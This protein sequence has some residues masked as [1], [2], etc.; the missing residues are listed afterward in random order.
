NVPKNTAS[1]IKNTQTSETLVPTTINDFGKLSL[2][3]AGASGTVQGIR[4][5]PLP[6]PQFPRYEMAGARMNQPN[7]VHDG[8]RQGQEDNFATSRPRFSS[9]G[10]PPRPLPPLTNQRVNPEE[11]PYPVDIEKI[12][13]LL[14]PIYPVQGTE[15]AM[16]I[17]EQH[18]QL[19]PQYIKLSEEIRR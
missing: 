10:R 17:Y 11:T 2:D 9:V 19:V 13:P 4:V 1:C 18:M 8:R 12:P 3:R 14:R 16:A 5:D 15:A 7:T 6:S